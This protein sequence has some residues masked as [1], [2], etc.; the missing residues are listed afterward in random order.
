MTSYTTRDR[1]DL[2]S[3]TFDFFFFCYR[4]SE[5][6]LSDSSEEEEQTSSETWRSEETIIARQKFVETNNNNGNTIG[7]NC[8]AGSSNISNSNNNNNNTNRK[9]ES[10]ESV[11]NEIS[12]NPVR[13]KNRT[14]SEELYENFVNKTETHFD[15]CGSLEKL[16]SEEERIPSLVSSTGTLVN[17][18]VVV[19]SSSCGGDACRICVN[20]PNKK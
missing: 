12:E 8:N 9:S 15:V 7:N 17:G 4:F 1:S 13:R 11:V 3:I 20:T 14:I 16:N 10:G 19:T 6:P 18:V 2:F 5:K